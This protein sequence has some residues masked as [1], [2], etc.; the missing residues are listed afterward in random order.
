[1][2][3]RKSTCAAPFLFLASKI[4]EAKRDPALWERVPD[5][6]DSKLLSKAE[7]VEI[8][9]KA[10]ARKAVLKRYRW[11]VVRPVLLEYDWCDFCMAVW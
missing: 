10:E 7:L 9:S 8:R 5:T 11:V 1:M 3:A 4:G 2:R 6:R